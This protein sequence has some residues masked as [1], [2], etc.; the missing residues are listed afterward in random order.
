[1]PQSRTILH[2]DLDAFFASC[3]LRRRPEL[4]G[5]PLA[6]GG[7]L[8][9]H[10]GERRRPGRGVVAAASY[11]ARPR[12]VSSA[13]PLAEAFRRCP[14]LVVLPVDIPHYAAASRE[15]FRIF[16]AYTPLVEPGSLDEAYLDVG[17]SHLLHGS[18]A[19]IAREIQTRIDRELSLPASVGVAT[20]K[21][22]AK[23]ASDLL[24]PRGLV[25]VHPG[26]EEAFLAP[27]PVARLPGAGPRT[28]ERLRLLG[29]RTLGQLAVAPS[30]LLVEVLGP[31]GQGLKARARG[32]DTAPVVVPTMPKSIS[33]EVTFDTD[34]FDRASLEERLRLLAAA[35]AARLRANSLKA[36]TVV[37]KVRLADFET[38]SRRAP[39]VRPSCADLE[40][41]RAARQLLRATLAEGRGVRLLGV[42]VEGLERPDPQMG[43]FDEVDRRLERVDLAMDGLRR[44]FGRTSIARGTAA[45]EDSP[46]WNHDHLGQLGRP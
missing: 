6:V 35:V 19:D 27:L 33:R 39:L 41:F 12:G 9:S 24:K 2:V 22:V 8:E 28:T 5:R 26:E 31:G 36:A 4:A 23:I 17:G 44:R 21:T 37:I 11:E 29:I 14:E 30:S 45:L 43:L 7:G 38:L 3:E 25:V 32:V 42:G 16:A 15:V 13:M 1:M 18:G 40:L 46:D 10:P 20:S 34:L